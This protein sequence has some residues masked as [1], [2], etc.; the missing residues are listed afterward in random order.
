[1]KEIKRDL[2]ECITDPAFDAICI[3]SNSQFGDDGKA[4]M[5]GGSAGVCA[6][7]WPQT[8]LRLGKC[9]KNF[10]DNI[11]FIIGT[12]DINGDY[13]EPNLK[14]IKSGGFKCLIFSFPTMDNMMDSAKIE[15][16]KRSSTLM[17]QN[18]D[19]YFLKGIAIGRMGSGTGGLNWNTDVKPIVSD[20]L[21]D[22][23]TI[24]SFPHED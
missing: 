17:M 18:A 1:M 2:F 14:T 13:I 19:R 6:R 23:F 7:R 3:N 4:F 22:R 9:L 24:V 20:I 16:I 8:E 12:V 10:E 15:L 5:S 21:D 11:P